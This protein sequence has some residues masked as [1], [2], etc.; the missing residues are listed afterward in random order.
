M[1]RLI[2]LITSGLIVI[3][4]L[5]SQENIFKK[6]EIPEKFIGYE[7]M[8]I[9][10]NDFA[11]YGG[12]TFHLQDYTDW[13]VVVREVRRVNY[14]VREEFTD[15]DFQKLNVSEE[16]I[17]GVTEDKYPCI[18]IFDFNENFIYEKDEVLIDEKADGLNGNEVWL[19]DL[20]NKQYD[21]VQYKFSNTKI[22]K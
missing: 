12:E 13:K 9:A 20:D 6:L 11:T 18:F 2:S 22:F 17:E 3:S 19:K 4:P 10:T 16:V 7:K 1:K 5:I 8:G 14:L 15:E 21:K